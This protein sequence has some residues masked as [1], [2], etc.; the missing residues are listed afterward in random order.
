L[1][2]QRLK[3]APEKSLAGR[4]RF[5]L[6]LKSLLAQS[7]AY[8]YGLIALLII[9]LASALR[10]LILQR[11]WPVLDSDEATTGLM[12]LHILKYGEHPLVFYGQDYVGTI[13]AYL[14]AFFFTLLGP[15]VFAL[16]LGLVLLFALFLASTYLLTSLLYSKKAALLALC[17][18]SL[19]S[20]EIFFRELEANGGYGEIIFFGS[21][22]L[23]LSSWLAMT[24]RQGPHVQQISWRRAFMYTLWSL[25]AGLALWSDPFILPFVFTSALLLLIFC[26]SELRFSI[27][28]LLVF[29]FLLGVSPQ[30][31]YKATTIQSPPTS[32]FGAG[33]PA[34]TQLNPSVQSRTTMISASGSTESVRQANL[35]GQFV[36]SVMVS[37]PVISGG[38]TLCAVSPKDAELPLDQMDSQT[39]QCT[40]VHGFWGLGYLTLLIIAMVG[41][42]RVY[43]LHWEQSTRLFAL[44]LSS[45]LWFRAPA[46]AQPLGARQATIRHA[47]RLIVL[48]SAA[49]TWFLYTLF[50]QAELSPWVSSRYLV[51]LLIVLPMLLAFL[52]ETTELVLPLTRSHILKV[53]SGYALL[54]LI[55]VTFLLGTLNIFNQFPSVQAQNAQQL[56]LLSDLRQIQTHHI[57]TDYWTCDRLAFQSLED[58]SCSVLQSQLDPGLNR[59]QPYANQVAH[60]SQSLYVFP[61]NSAQDINFAQL[62]TQSHL[63]YSRLIKDGY[64]IYLP[65]GYAIH[66]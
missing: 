60:D 41:A 7:H 35:L 5:G 26:R 36:G 9:L 61:V 51:G 48:A 10:I 62:D 27:I 45:R 32:L 6:Y 34:Q 64:A 42:Y 18:L 30:L 28:A 40:F 66:V 65:E 31:L 39:L 22:L 29:G 20:P 21:L 56:A 1:D 19:G 44:R 25:V 53:V 4:S 57:Y 24:S 33:I 63:H 17:V 3:L 13:Q 8:L 23:L 12:A 49:L 50:P 54:L 59:Y 14:A 2:T 37:V 52:W 55:S 38:T 47:A 46:P 58:I 16:R 15:S 43:W 11:G